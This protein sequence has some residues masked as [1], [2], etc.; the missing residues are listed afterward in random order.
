[1][2]LAEERREEL[3]DAAI[4]LGLPRPSNTRYGCGIGP[5]RQSAAPWD[6]A[7]SVPLTELELTMKAVAVQYFT[8]QLK[9]GD[10]PPALTRAAVDRL[11]A[12]SEV[13]FV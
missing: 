5:G 8:S 9:P 2:E 10:G 12:V 7:R 13:V 11:L 6:R 3:L 4:R 1:V